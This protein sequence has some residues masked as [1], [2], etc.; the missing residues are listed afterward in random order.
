MFSVVGIVP[1]LGGFA[2]ISERFRGLGDK[3]IKAGYLRCVFSVLFFS[4]WCW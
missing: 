3:T 4:S 2:D 1:K